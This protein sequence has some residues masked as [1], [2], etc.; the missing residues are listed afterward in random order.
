MEAA[1]DGIKCI[2][3]N[4]GVRNF[5]LYDPSI[6]FVLGSDDPAGLE[7][8]LEMPVKKYSEDELKAFDFKE[9]IKNMIKS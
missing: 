4:E 7:S 1:F 3:N 9:R 2:T 6:Y 8:F 5:E